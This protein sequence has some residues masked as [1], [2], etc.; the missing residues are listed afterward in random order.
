MGSGLIINGESATSIYRFTTP[1]RTGLTESSRVLDAYCGIGTIGLVK[2]V[3]TY[4]VEKNIKSPCVVYDGDLNI[5]LE[6]NESDVGA[7][8]FRKF[9]VGS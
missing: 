3:N 5:A 4:K 9:N 8:N 6:D 7:C 2:A 1:I